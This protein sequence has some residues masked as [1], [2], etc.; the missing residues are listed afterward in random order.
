MSVAIESFE[1]YERLEQLEACS[2][3]PAELG[4]YV[5]CLDTE[6]GEEFRFELWDESDGWY[7]Q[8]ELLDEWLASRRYIVLKA[9]QLGITWL[10]ALLALWYLLFKPGTRVLIVS[11]NEKEASKVIGR[12]WIMY[13][14][15]PAHLCRHATIVKPSRGADPSDTIEVRHE[16]GKKSTILA[17]PSTPKAGHGETAALVILD[18]LARQDYAMQTWTAVIP[19]AAKGGLIIGISTGNGVSTQEGQG[20]FF[21]FL[22]RGADEAQVRK[23][24]LSVFTHPDR[25][26]EWYQRE[27]MAIPLPSVRGEQYPRTE[28]EAF[29]LT[30]D[31]YFDVDALAWYDE[32]GLREPL[33]RGRYVREGEA[34][35]SRFQK[36]ELGPVRIF[37][38][39]DG[40]HDYLITA[41]VATGRGKDYSAAYVLDL[42]T[43][44]PVA[45]VQAKIP[46]DLYAEQL[47]CLARYY[48]DAKIAVENAGGF[49]D[50]VII[51]LRERKPWRP[52]YTNLHQHV[53]ELEWGLPERK[54]LGY[55]VNVHTRPQM[56]GTLAAALREHS[57]PYVSAECLAELQTF[58]HR[59]TNPS[60]RA[61]EGC[62]DDRVMALAAACDL[63]RRYGGERKERKPREYRP[64]RP[65]E[66]RKVA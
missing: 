7:W 66:S 54:G 64:S 29:I 11:I 16:D 40:K 5:R 4:R 36:L 33:F 44:A 50:A 62:N 3:H 45:E 6:E 52:A 38:P 24:F 60:P 59:D 27:A 55:P 34:R 49:G 19:T 10:S 13:Q 28:R 51:S 41:D 56:L 23:R 12:I 18:E 57:L 43:M 35:T 21:H 42:V 65:W 63:Y 22:W 39:A 14:S 53:H 2:R 25:D 1:E 46:A 37:E 8:R 26:E 58:V 9:R 15:L 17:L 61:Q 31:P 48:G 30:G 20:N 47:Y 32:F